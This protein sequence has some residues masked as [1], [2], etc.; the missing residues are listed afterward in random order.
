MAVTLHALVEREVRE[1]REAM[2]T[3]GLRSIPIYPE[4][5]ACSAPTADKILGLFEGLRRH[6]L[7][8]NGQTIQTFWDELTGAQRLVLDLLRMPTTVY[9]Q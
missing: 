6:R 4:E 5:R 8:R 3:R 1:V 9:G 2:K 7:F